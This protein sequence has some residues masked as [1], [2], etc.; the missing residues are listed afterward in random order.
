[1]EKRAKSR[2]FL[3]E[4]LIV[5]LFFSISAVIIV[6]LFVNA[7]DKI[8][9]STNKTKANLLI[10]N[11]IEDVKNKIEND[12]LKD[13]KDINSYYNNEDNDG[14]TL[15]INIKETVTKAGVL[16]D[17]QITAKKNKKILT[18]LEFSHYKSN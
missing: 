17:G 18:E 6:Q 7:S 2:A 10:T 8:N 16:Y 4:F 11:A 3:T 5:I 1:M 15:N 13:I 12:T 14:I 9:E